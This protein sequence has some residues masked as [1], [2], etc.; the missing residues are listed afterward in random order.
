MRTRLL[1]VAGIADHMTSFAL[2]FYSKSFERFLELKITLRCILRT[3][4]ENLLLSLYSNEIIDDVLG[5]D[6]VCP[7]EL[8]DVGPFEQS[9]L[10][11][12]WAIHDKL[13]KSLHHKMMFLDGLAFA[14]GRYI[15]YFLMVCPF[16][17]KD[18]LPMIST[19]LEDKT[20]DQKSKEIA[21][22]VIAKIM[23]TVPTEMDCFHATFEINTTFSLIT[24]MN[25]ISGSTVD[26]ISA[27]DF[28]KSSLKI[29]KDGPVSKSE[30]RNDWNPVYPIPF[31]LNMLKSLHDIGEIGAEE[32]NETFDYLITTLKEYHEKDTVFVT[33]IK[34][35]QKRK[36]SSPGV[37]NSSS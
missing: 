33:D 4:I 7:Y 14:Y 11:A 2:D 24:K 35:P 37:T 18:M 17:C 30:I 25:E 16:F 19:L 9:L 34:S 3:N 23:T 26:S 1:F 22:S 10:F 32:E 20:K 21:K 12:M 8:P 27:K 15:L 28:I 5:S 6:F 36:R 13:D 31:I 29:D